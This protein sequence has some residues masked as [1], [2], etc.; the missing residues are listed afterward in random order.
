MREHSIFPKIYF[1]EK[2]KEKKEKKGKKKKKKGAK[3][4]KNKKKIPKNIFSEIF[5]DF[6]GIFSERRKRYETKK[7]KRKM[8]KKK[9]QKK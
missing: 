4:P 5:R 7:S 9:N 6:L 3:C 8:Y 2:I 1:W